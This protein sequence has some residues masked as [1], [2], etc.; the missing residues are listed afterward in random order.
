MNATTQAETSQIVDLGIPIHRKHLKATALFAGEDDIRDYINGVLVHVTDKAV[1][2]V[3]TNGQVL[4]VTNAEFEEPPLVPAGT[5]IIVPIDVVKRFAADS[6]KT[7]IY[8]SPVGLERYKL[9]SHHLS[10]NF[11]PIQGKFPD[12]EVMG[13]FDAKPSGEVGDYNPYYVSLFGKAASVYCKAGPLVLIEHNGE[14]AALVHTTDPDF[15]GVLMPWSV[16]LPRGV[17]AWLKPRRDL[18]DMESA[19]GNLPGFDPE[20]EDDGPLNTAGTGETPASA[21]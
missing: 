11:T 17:P 21:P 2:L 1:R 8:L 6:D 12:Y 4:A 20:D 13:L 19:S 16:L 18:L 3:A 10:I 14:K 5:K 9:E 7:P 15:I